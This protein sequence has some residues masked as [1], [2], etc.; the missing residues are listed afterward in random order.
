MCYIIPP[1]LTISQKGK[2]YTFI[3]YHL[4]QC[5][6]SDVIIVTVMNMNQEYRCH[7]CD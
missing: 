3:I 2:W 7:L 4:I 6:T 1:C 5:I